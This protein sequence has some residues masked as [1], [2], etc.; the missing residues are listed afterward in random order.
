MV[1]EGYK[2]TEIGV[3]PDDWEIK[4][5][6]D[7]TDGRAGGTPNTKIKN[8]WGGNIRW[9]NSGELNNKI[10]Y[11]V[12]GRITEDGLITVNQKLI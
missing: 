12:K 1:A 4:R 10:I 11:D 2:Q 8:F 6:K 5:I 9:I 3:I 7:F